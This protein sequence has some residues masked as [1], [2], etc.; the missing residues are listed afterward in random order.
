MGELEKYLRPVISC[1]NCARHIAQCPW[2]HLGKPVP[3]WK[4]TPHE[5]VVGN[6]KNKEPI[7][8]TGYYI[9]ECPLYIAAAPRKSDPAELTPAQSDWLLRK[10]K[11]K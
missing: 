11:R 1:G 3:G 2:L 9:R 10:E 6:K 4:A 8:V 7:W 5:F